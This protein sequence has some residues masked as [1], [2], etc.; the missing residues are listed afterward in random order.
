MS[1]AYSVVIP[2]YNAAATIGATLASVLTQTVAPE[3][4][5]VVNDGSRDETAKLAAGASDKVTVVDQANS[6][7]GPATTAGFRHVSTPLVATLD[8]DDLW[9][10]QKIE[11][12]SQALVRDP[13][14]SGVFSLARQFSDGETADPNGV[15]AVRRLWTRTTML[16]RS[17]AAR[18]VGP[19]MDF[20][21]RLGDFI[22]WLARARALGQRDMMI[23][24]I[25]AMRRVR[26]DSLS[27][28]SLRQGGVRGYLAVANAALQR[29]KQRPNSEGG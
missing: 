13:G 16:Y 22:D 2:A 4:I 17:E 19:F 21:E 15:G 14:L 7:P 24:E 26:T 1:L 27:Q 5:I 8:A 10:P 20:P 28:E 18:R 12:Q 25:L 3:A 23:E 6:G 29:R 9:L 11:R